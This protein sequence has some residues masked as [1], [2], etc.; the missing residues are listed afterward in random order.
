MRFLHQR[1]DQKGYTYC[2]AYKQI[3]AAAIRDTVE[4]H[5]KNRLVSLI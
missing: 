2:L 4:Q 1:Y 3:N 5:L